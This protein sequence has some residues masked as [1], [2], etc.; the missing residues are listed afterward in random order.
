MKTTDAHGLAEAPRGAILEHVRTL[1]RRLILD[2]VEW[3][4]DIEDGP[5]GAALVRFLKHEDPSPDVSL[6][7]QELDRQLGVATR[8]PQVD[9]DSRF[10]LVAKRLGLSRVAF[11]LL[12]VLVAPELDERF[13]A[14]YRLLWGKPDQRHCDEDFLAAMLRLGSVAG[15]R[16]EVPDDHVI[17]RLGVAWRLHRPG[18][19]ATFAL[20][21][22]LLLEL[23]GQ[24]SIPTELAGHARHR[25][26]HEDPIDEIWTT[27]PLLEETRTALFSSRP[28]VL[29]E[30]HTSDA[31]P[32]MIRDAVGRFGHGSLT[33]D[34]GTLLRPEEHP[35]LFAN[36]SRLLRLILR[37]ARLRG[38]ALILDG[39]DA[40][41]S[42]PSSLLDLFIDFLRREPGPVYLIARRF[43]VDLSGRLISGLSPSHIRVP[44]TSPVD[45][46]AMWD[47]AL[48]AS[49]RDLPD[50]E[51]A[52]LAAQPL[53]PAAIVRAIRVS[54]GTGR[55]LVQVA[56][57][58]T[59]S[60]LSGLATRVTP[61]LDWKDLVFPKA[62]A[63]ELDDVAVFARHRELI[64]ERWGL[65]RTEGNKGIKVLLS[66]PPGTGKTAVS[67]LL[68]REAGC[69]L[70]RVDTG[71]VVSK[72]LGETEKHL[73]ELFE[74][75][76]EIGAALLFDEADS[77]FARRVDV[78]S[79]NDRYAN[80]SVNHLLQ[81]IEDHPGFVVLTT[82]N[83]Q[84]LD[85]AF[86]RRL[87][88]HIQFPS[89]TE[90]DREKL[91]RSHLPRSTP[92]SLDVDV[93]WLATHFE[94]TGGQI[95]QAVMR[96]A[97]HALRGGRRQIG[98][99]D[100]EAGCRLVYRSLG[101]LPPAV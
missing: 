10:R 1:V 45:R 96:A 68:A 4:P 61:H 25:Q 67:A 29:L 19:S 65:A 15:L 81:L 89:P 39:V 75:A 42:L 8:P 91:W 87:S 52:R 56:S 80:Q 40:L 30:G 58:L 32:T 101:R 24:P 64:G 90:D 97:V 9:I 98:Q 26:P 44:A 18:E 88:F 46:R 47:H 48:E 85:S 16:H 34:M 86:A 53:G 59:R 60:R 63:E 57:E 33:V 51:L 84:L 83:D 2:R 77:L 94:L 17:W 92:L 54:A 28:F 37:E 3:L 13:L 62:L 66:G 14:T 72:W 82:N 38:A 100:L 36:G 22:R 55:D 50:S 23:I 78:Q 95:R 93:R 27:F 5:S 11:E 43:S 49:G 20:D 41:E 35:A 76:K 99:V 69:E 6:A 79:S 73:S 71:A 7:V 12:A 21:D 31:I 70:Y 74:V